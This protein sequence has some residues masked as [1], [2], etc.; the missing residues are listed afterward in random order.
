M[1]ET[2]AESVAEQ[3]AHQPR[4]S[5]YDLDRAFR[6]IRNAQ[7]APGAFLMINLDDCS[8]HVSSSF[9]ILSATS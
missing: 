5:I 3:I 9:L 1:A 2:C 8:L 4:F 6:A 7:P